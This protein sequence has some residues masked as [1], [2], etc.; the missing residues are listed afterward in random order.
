MIL[1]PGKPATEAT[2]YQT[3]FINTGTVKIFRKITSEKIK[4][5][6]GWKA[7]NTNIS[8]WV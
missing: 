2:S 1:K 6:T 4:T 7:D 3:T 5:K 8:V